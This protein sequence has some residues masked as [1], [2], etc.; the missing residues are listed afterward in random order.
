MHQ[1]HPPTPDSPPQLRDTSLTHLA[2]PASGP[3][4]RPIPI[5]YFPFQGYLAYKK[6]H[7]LGPYRR[8]MSRVLEESKGGGRFL[9]GEILL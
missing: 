4:P 6:T 5:A 3:T 9:M 1:R 2:Y 7:P 8:P